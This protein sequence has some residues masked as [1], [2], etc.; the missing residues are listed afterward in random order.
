MTNDLET[1][2]LYIAEQFAV[3]LPDATHVD[4]VHNDDETITVTVKRRNLANQTFIMYI[5]SDD[6]EYHFTLQNVPCQMILSFP[7]IDA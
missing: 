3:F 7:F 4:V 1:I 6:D 2:E 5:N